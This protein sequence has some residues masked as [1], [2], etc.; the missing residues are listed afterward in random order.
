M[1]DA[2]GKRL[3]GA[4]AGWT[5]AIWQMGSAVSPLAVGHVYGGTHSIVLA[6]LT[7]A[8]RPV[9]GLIAMLFVS[10]RIARI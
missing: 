2:S 10:R 3:A 7:L 1:S 8:I 4:S 5:N 6:V 9:I